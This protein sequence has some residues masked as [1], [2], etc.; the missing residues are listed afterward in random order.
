MLAIFDEGTSVA[1]VSRVQNAL[2]AGRNGA[3]PGSRACAPAHLSSIPATPTPLPAK[4][5]RAACAFTAKLAAA[6]AGCKAAEVFL[7]STGVI[8][9]PLPRAG[10]RWRYDQ[11][12]C[13]GCGPNA[14]EEAAR[15]NQ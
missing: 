10:V 2:G 9:E 7:A 13:C 4:A 11:A 6:A 15:A 3:A 8:G 5:A 14:Y 12:R 1:G